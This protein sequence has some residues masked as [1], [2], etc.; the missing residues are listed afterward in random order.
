MKNRAY[1]KPLKS[2]IYL[3]CDA[4]YFHWK[5]NKC[6]RVIEDGKSWIWKETGSSQDRKSVCSDNSGQNTW[7]KIE[8]PSKTGQ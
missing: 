7:N 2:I 5:T 4:L 8:K 3:I 1:A 6:F